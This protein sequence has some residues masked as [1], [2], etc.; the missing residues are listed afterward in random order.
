MARWIGLALIPLL[1]VAALLMACSAGDDSEEY[2]SAPP[3]ATAAPIATVAAAPTAAPRPTAA[4]VVTADAPSGADGERL[5]FQQVGTGRSIVYVGTMFVEVADVGLATQQAQVAIAGLGGLVFGQH[6]TSDPAPRTELTFKV[7]PE[8]FTEAMRRLEALG[9]LR[10]QQISADDVTERVVDLES[11]IITAR[12]SVERL[13]NFLANAT[14]LETVAELES[15]LLNRETDLERLRG[16]LRTLQDQVALATIFLTLVEPAPERPEASVELVQTAYAGHDDGAR[17][18]AADDLAV[19]E[20]EAITICVSV[21][22]TGNAALTEI[23]IRDFGLDLDDDDFVA[24][25]GSVAGPLQPGERLLGYFLTEAEL[26]TGP[27]PE[28]SAVAVD[29]DGEPLR[30]TVGADYDIFEYEVIEDDSLPTFVDG[31][32]GSWSAVVTLARLGVLAL[33]VAIPF[34][35]IVPFAAGLFWLGR[36]LGRRLNRR[37][38]RWDEPRQPRG[39]A[40][41]TPE[42]RDGPE[43]E[44]AD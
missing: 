25:E 22:N 8:D 42:D 37:L 30:I 40:G 20:G 32:R 24:L 17:C 29:P 9:K 31:L 11:R 15:Q 33:G 19:D 38:N 13:R 2:A 7:L 44:S 28:V 26:G 4:A 6:T 35:W 18:P 21:E 16:Q 23:E 41:T 27:V 36:R 39:A 5:A 3:A 10:S 14:D 1:L 43:A 34:L 12:A